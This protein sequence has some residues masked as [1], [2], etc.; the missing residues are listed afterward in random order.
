MRHF[1]AVAEPVATDNFAELRDIVLDGVLP[2]PSA[3]EDTAGEISTFKDRYDRQLRSFRRRIEREVRDLGRIQDE[4]ERAV[5]VRD[6]Q[7]DLG[8]EIEDLTARMHEQGWREV[9]HGSLSALAVLAPVAAAA[10]TGEPL[11]ALLGVPALAETAFELLRPS[12]HVGDQTLAYAALAQ[13]VWGQ[14]EG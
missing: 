11:A 3:L 6:V 13:R 2:A 1:R 14:A 4:V 7:S 8:E 10:V 5:R 12:G 9:T